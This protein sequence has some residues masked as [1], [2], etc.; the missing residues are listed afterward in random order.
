MKMITIMD[1][2]MSKV[3]VPYTPLSRALALSSS[4]QQ[5]SRTELSRARH[6]KLGG[7]VETCVYLYIIPLHEEEQ[8]PPQAPRRQ[9]LPCLF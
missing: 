5:S 3:R 2:M 1:M 4:L 6:P 7:I 8:E 9:F